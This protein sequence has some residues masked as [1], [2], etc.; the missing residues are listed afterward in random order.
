MWQEPVWSESTREVGGSRS[1]GEERGSQ[2]CWRA[3]G[4]PDRAWGSRG[5]PLAR[6]SGCVISLIAAERACGSWVR[7]DQ[8]L[9]LSMKS[10]FVF[11]LD[12]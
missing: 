2:L 11:V 4:A 9:K 3:G 5:E 1:D 10:R 7:D 8:W 12:K 6:L